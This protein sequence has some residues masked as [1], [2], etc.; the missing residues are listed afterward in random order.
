M[1]VHIAHFNEQQQLLLLLLQ[2]LLYKEILRT[3][4]LKYLKSVVYTCLHITYYYIYLIVG[5]FAEIPVAQYLLT[6][7]HCMY[8]VLFM[9][10][11]FIVDVCL[12]PCTPNFLVECWKFVIGRLT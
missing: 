12:T 2:Q 8:F 4:Y 11:F 5:Q 3:I 6:Y 1:I 9:R 10:M 7:A